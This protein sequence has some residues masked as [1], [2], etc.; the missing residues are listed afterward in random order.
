MTLQVDGQQAGVRG[1]SGAA[2]DAPFTVRLSRG[3][4]GVRVRNTGGE[5]TLPAVEV[6]A[7]GM[8]G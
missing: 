5:S 7:A 2:A 3:T 4:H 6:S 1:D 8:A